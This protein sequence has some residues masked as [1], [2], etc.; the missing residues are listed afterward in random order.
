[1]DFLSKI[2]QYMQTTTQQVNP[3][4]GGQSV[5]PKVGGAG[6]EPSFIERISA[7]GGN[8]YGGLRHDPGLV[9]RLDAL[10]PKRP[11]VSGTCGFDIL[12]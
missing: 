8:E 3:Y 10:D 5:T 7:I 2:G 9:A 11:D 4:N 1:M 6:Q 12:A